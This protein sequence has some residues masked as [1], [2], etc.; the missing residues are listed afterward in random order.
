M[1]LST[2]KKSAGALRAAEAAGRDAARRCLIDLEAMISVI[3]TEM[4][5]TIPAI[6][7]DT[8]MM[9]WVAFL[10]TLAGHAALSLG[11]QNAIRMLTTVLDA[12]KTQAAHAH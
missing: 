2:D 1:H 11:P 5:T 10:S 3:E 8:I 7:A 4:R 6:R 12:A 9:L